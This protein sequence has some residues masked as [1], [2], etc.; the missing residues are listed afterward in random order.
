MN[1]MRG[2]THGHAKLDPVLRAK[3]LVTAWQLW[4]PEAWKAAAA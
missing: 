4:V 2:L 1:A 3:K